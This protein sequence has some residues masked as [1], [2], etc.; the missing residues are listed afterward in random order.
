VYTLTVGQQQEIMLT[1]VV[2]NGGEE[3]HRALLSVML[4][5]NL[6]YVGTGTRVCVKLLW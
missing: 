5:P 1:A 6:H 4:P 3:A 2:Y